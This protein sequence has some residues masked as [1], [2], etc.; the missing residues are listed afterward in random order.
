MLKDI[1]GRAAETVEFPDGAQVESVFAHYTTQFPRL[2]ELRRSIVPA[3]NQQFCDPATELSDGDE[4]AFLPPVSG[5]ADAPAIQLAIQKDAQFTHVIEEEAGHFF[6]PTRRAIDG[7][8]L[9]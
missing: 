2:A 1:A 5:G 3:R 4:L 9:I 6:A 7:R 8:A